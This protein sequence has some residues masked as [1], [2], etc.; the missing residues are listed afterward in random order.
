M[1]REKICKT[2]DG[3]IVTILVCYINLKSKRAFEQTTSQI[4]ILKMYSQIFDITNC[5]CE[6]LCFQW[7][8]M[9]CFCVVCETLGH[10][11]ITL[12]VS[13]W[14]SDFFKV[15]TLSHIC[16]K[17]PCTTLHYHN[18]LIQLYEAKAKVTLWL[19][20][21]HTFL[22]KYTFT[23]LLTTSLYYLKLAGNICCCT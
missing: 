12:T 10:I 8:H 1:Y 15:V 21:S 17:L 13:L 14:R 22:V 18:I 7:Q 2:L 3:M 4:C 11:G 16:L 19:W 9:D 23:Y 6:T 20:L 5:V